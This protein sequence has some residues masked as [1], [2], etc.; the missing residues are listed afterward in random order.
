M[1]RWLLNYTPQATIVRL[2]TLSC[3][4]GSVAS[5]LVPLL[6]GDRSPALLLPAWI[7][8]A[9]TL[10]ACY[11]ASQRRINIRKETSASVSAFSIASFISMLALLAN[12]HLGAVP[13]RRDA[14]PDIPLVALLQRAAE[15]GGR[16]IVAVLGVNRERDGL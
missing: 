9:T 6:A 4:L 1:S 7:G 11:H 16:L 15:I 2:A 13:A 12:L 10:T 8:I 5:Q 3:I 14:Y